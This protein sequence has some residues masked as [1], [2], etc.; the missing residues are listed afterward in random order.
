MAFH[1]YGVSLPPL[2][3][4]PVI[5]TRST[6]TA[7][8]SPSATASTLQ[9]AGSTKRLREILLLSPTTTAPSLT[10][11]TAVRE[12]GMRRGKE[13]SK[14]VRDRSGI[15]FFQRHPLDS[16]NP[17]TFLGVGCGDG[18]AGG[19]ED[20]ATAGTVEDDAPSEIAQEEKGEEV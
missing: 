14:R 6:A 20:A 2:D 15:E 3:T 7:T 13:G 5:L 12:E 4:A 11:P 9:R 1:K 18:D 17:V 16:R 19:G 10:A 8:L